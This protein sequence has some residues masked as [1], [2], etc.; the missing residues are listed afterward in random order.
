VAV[1]TGGAASPQLL[2]QFKELHSEVLERVVAEV[3][4]WRQHNP[5]AQFYGR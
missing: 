2:L 5:G 4:G 3:V 1:A